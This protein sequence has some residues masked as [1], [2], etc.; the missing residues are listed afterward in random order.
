MQRTTAGPGEIHATPA[1]QVTLI[2]NK[3][4]DNIIDEL[5]H[6]DSGGQVNTR[7]YSGSKGPTLLI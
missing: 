4:N 5:Y 6:Q 2:P 1:A 7:D 3:Y